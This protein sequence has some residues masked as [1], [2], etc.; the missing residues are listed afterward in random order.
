[1]KPN[2]DIC[3]GSPEQKAQMIFE[4]YDLDH[5]GELNREEGS[6]MIR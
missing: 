5:S 3:A 1:M 6:N 4:M 2:V